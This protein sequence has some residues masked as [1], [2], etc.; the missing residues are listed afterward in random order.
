[1]A[2]IRVRSSHISGGGPPILGSGLGPL[3]SDQGMRKT[4]GKLA[5]AGWGVARGLGS[6]KTRLGI[7]HAG[8]PRPTS[9]LMQR[10]MRIWPGSSPWS[11]LAERPE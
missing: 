6:K 2:T 3:G 1:M 5:V 7:Q 4:E 8:A 11:E 10:C 9:F